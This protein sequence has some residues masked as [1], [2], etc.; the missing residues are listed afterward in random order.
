MIRMATMTPKERISRAARGLEV[1]RVPSIGGWN[2]GVRNLAALAGI[3]VEEYL[4]NPAAAVLRA[5]HMLGVDAMV[6]PIVPTRLDEMR[7]GHVTESDY[8]GTPAEAIVECANA[9]PDT[10]AEV[11]RQAKFDPAAEERSMREMFLDSRKNWGGIERIPN[12]W[13]LGGPFGLYWQFGYV[14][15][16]EA[17]ALYPEAVGKIWWA[18]SL[19]ARKRALIFRDLYREF[20]LPPV[21]FCGEDMCNNQG[22]MLSPAMLRQHY[23]P[24]VKAIIDPL[25]EAG[26]RVVHHCD[27]DVRPLV[28]DFLDMGFSGFQGFQY[29]VGM[30]PAQLR[31]LRS[32]RGE[33]PIF[34]MGLSVSRTLPFG[35]QDDARDEVDYF[36][37]VTDGGRGMFLFTANVTGVE[38]PAENIRAAYARV[39]EFDPAQPRARRFA[40]WPWRLKHPQAV[41]SLG[42]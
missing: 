30:D 2:N 37:D 26:I 8:E 33:V 35:T 4:A 22:P 10:E 40:E 6:G 38:V 20:D 32:K 3:S 41:G 31:N 14:A 24:V 13:D 11:L 7:T 36:L 34:F 1:D 15:F 39:K 23:F 42:A 12:F 28:Q 25:V 19:A 27:G 29:E 5:N 17:C 21:L 9:L 16:F 18:R